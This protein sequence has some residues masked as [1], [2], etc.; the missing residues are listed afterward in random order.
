M[1]SLYALSLDISLLYRFREFLAGETIVVSMAAKE[2]Y[3]HRDINATAQFCRKWRL[4]QGFRAEDSKNQDVVLNRHK[5]RVDYVDQLMER[6]Y[7]RAE[8]TEAW[9][10]AINGGANLLFNLQQTDTIAESDWE[11][12]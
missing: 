9:K 12:N 1:T 6:S 5:Q 10:I 4:P 8:A 3:C 2:D 7:T 11:R